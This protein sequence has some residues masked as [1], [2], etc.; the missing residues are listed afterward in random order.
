VGAGARHGRGS[1]SFERLLW[2]PLTIPGAR[3]SQARHDRVR[4]A[5][6]R[7]QTTMRH[8]RTHLRWRV[9]L[10]ALHSPLHGRCDVSVGVHLARNRAAAHAIAGLEGG[11]SVCVC[12]F[13]YERERCV[14]GMPVCVYS[15]LFAHT[16]EAGRLNIHRQA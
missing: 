6:T 11:A 9:Y 2:W 16:G 1:A 7:A 13:V 4:T 12:V 5:H 3:G 8:M 14:C 15:R 10:E